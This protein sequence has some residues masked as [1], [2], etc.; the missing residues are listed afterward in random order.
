MSIAN[1]FERESS[2]LTW[3]E[4]GWPLSFRQGVR[5]GAGLAALAAVVA[6]AVSGHGFVAAWLGLML[7]TWAFLIGAARA[8]AEDD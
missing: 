1:P 6:L 5:V 2:L 8:S 4:F 3:R 7:V